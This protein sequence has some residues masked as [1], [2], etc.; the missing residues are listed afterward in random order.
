MTKSLN[1][2][3]LLFTVLVSDIGI[4]VE[5]HRNDSTRVGFLVNCLQALMGSNKI[6]LF[7]FSA[8]L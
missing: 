3:E 6:P 5:F 8:G 4:G 1:K 7:A 2:S